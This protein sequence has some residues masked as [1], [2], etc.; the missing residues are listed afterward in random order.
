MLIKNYQQCRVNCHDIAQGLKRIE[1]GRLKYERKLTRR[2]G[3]SPAT[4][5]QRTA[6]IER[7][8]AEFD[9]LEKNSRVTLECLQIEAWQARYA[10][11]AEGIEVL[12]PLPCEGEGFADIPSQELE[13]RRLSRHHL[14]RQFINGLE[15]RGEHR[16]G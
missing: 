16:H 7:R 4:A 2:R 9:W 3:Y 1:S 12:P 15:S 8:L 11:L 6:E 5:G 14:A 10:C 13:R